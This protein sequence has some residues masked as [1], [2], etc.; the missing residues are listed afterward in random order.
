M[1]LWAFAVAV[2]GGIGLEEV[3][4][5]VGRRPLVKHG[6]DRGPMLSRAVVGAVVL[7]TFA[8]LFTYGRAIHP[9]SRR[10]S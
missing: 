5:L 10:S 6:K 9:P 4:S 2:L 3:Q 1:F 8:Q 7:V